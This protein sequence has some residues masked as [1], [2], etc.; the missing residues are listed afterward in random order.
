[1]HAVADA[2][3]H[4]ASGGWH[5]VKCWTRVAAA[6]IVD[7]GNSY[8][9]VQVGDD[10]G[11]LLLALERCALIASRRALGAVREHEP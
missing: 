3:S 8:G 4:L 2:F 10:G 6:N 5:D 11:S 9:N 7:I 1:M